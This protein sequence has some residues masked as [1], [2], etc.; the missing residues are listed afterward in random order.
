ILT[1]PTRGSR[2]G[3]RAASRRRRSDAFDRLDRAA[4]HGLDERGVVAL[5][6]VRVR[7]REGHQGLVE[8]GAAT[9]V[10]ADGDRIARAGVRPGERPAAD[11][12]IDAQPLG[13]EGR[14]VEAALAVL[15]LAEVEV[16]L[17]PV[18]HDPTVPTEE[19]VAGRLHEPLPRDDPAP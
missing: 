5:V 3:G 4:A 18:R 10:G 15:E 17:H 14:R 2:T 19:D 9:E 11:L 7:L 13:P 1:R 12:A 16:A 8:R 6:L